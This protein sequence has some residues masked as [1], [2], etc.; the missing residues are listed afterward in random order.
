MVSTCVPH[1]FH[2]RSMLCLRAEY[3]EKCPNLVVR[4]GSYCSD[5]KCFNSAV[6]NGEYKCTRC[7]RNTCFWCIV[8][9]HDMREDLKKDGM[10]CFECYEKAVGWKIIPKPTMCRCFFKYGLP[11][12]NENLR[13]HT[14]FCE[15]LKRQYKHD[16]GD[17]VEK[18][19]GLVDWRRNRV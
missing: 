16:I 1:T 2:T 9:P 17:S 15:S 3:R 19:Y 13:L 4:G 12:T 8:F 14:R 11:S 18:E 6:D 10:Q 5:H 7:D